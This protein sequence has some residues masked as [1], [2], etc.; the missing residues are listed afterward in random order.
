[1]IDQLPSVEE[2][3]ERK[4]MDELSR[5]LHSYDTGKITHREM[6]LMLDTLWA[7]VSGLTSEDW[8]EMI[9]AARQ[10]EDDQVPLEFHCLRDTTVTYASLK[11]D[12]D[13]LVVVFHNHE[14]AV[15]RSTMHNFAD[16]VIPAQAARDAMRMLIT[17]L[18]SKGFRPLCP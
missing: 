7:C 8:R 2:E 11:R 1:M 14:G 10:I 13:S 5:I 16:E 6:N 18:T 12:D 4:A 17:A 3:L 15:T 9:E